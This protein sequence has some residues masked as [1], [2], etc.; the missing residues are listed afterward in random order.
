M[1]THS[2]LAFVGARVRVFSALRYRD[3]RLYWIGQL[4]TVSGLQMIILAE[5]WLLWMLRGSELLLGAVGGIRAVPAVVLSL[6]GGAVA[7][8]VELRRFLIL[9]ESVAAFTLLVLAT[10]AVTGLVQIWHIFAVAFTFGIIQATAKI[11]RI[12]PTT[13]RVRF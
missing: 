7:D 11:C 6:F 2:I 12:E 1:S 5:G 10:L 4:V 13:S 9:I 8:K 3:F